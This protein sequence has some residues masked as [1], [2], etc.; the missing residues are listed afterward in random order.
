MT[1]NHM[2]AIG[3]AFRD[4]EEKWLGG[5]TRFIGRCIVLLDELWTIHDGLLYARSSNYRCIEIESNNLEVVHIVTSA[6]STMRGSAL[7][8]SIK[9]WLNKDWQVKV[10]HVGRAL[11]HVANR[12]ASIG[13]GRN[14][15]ATMLTVV[16]DD[17]CELVEEERLLSD[18]IGSSLVSVAIAPFDP[19]RG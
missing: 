15:E 11:N 6:S 7:V 17:V 16:S 5:F 3:A 2:A 4:S 12:L 14:F 13:R 18:P 1:S 10:L 8:L 19:G 9:R